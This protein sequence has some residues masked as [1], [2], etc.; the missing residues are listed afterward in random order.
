M[1]R[2]ITFGT[3]DLFHIG[4]LKILERSAAYGNKL[5]VGVSS[6]D[7]NYKKKQEYPTYPEHERMAIV[8]ALEC[9]STVFLEESLELKC[10]YVKRYRADI[11]VMGND[12]ENEFDWV[13]E[14]TGCEV[15]Y[16]PRTEGI[17]SSGIKKSLRSVK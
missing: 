10:E 2:I 15:I 17:S 12:W 1:T 4:H 14:E 13:G 11:L 6:D 7:L 3:F 5:I 8:E 9:V 16:L